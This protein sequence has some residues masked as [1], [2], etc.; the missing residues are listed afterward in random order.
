MITISKQTEELFY[1][2]VRK[3]PEQK[4]RT[5]LKCGRVRNM[6]GRICADCKDLNSSF[7]FRAEGVVG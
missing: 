4:L 3:P 7:S 5:C 2:L 6:K 1:S